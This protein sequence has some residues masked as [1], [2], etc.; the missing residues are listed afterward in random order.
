MIK[1][2]QDIDIA[3]LA[4]GDV[5]LWRT[6]VRRISPVV[7]SVIRGTLISAGRD[8]GEAHDL[9]Q[10]LFLRLCKDN[11]RLLKQYNPERARLSTWLAVIA[12]NMTIDYL[13]RRRPPTISL[14]EIPEQGSEETGI[15][16]EMDGIVISFQVL[17][18]R[19]MMVMKLMYEK[20]MDVKEVADFMG[21]T[22]Q[23]VRSMHHKA[24]KKLRSIV[25]DG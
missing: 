24:V 7:F 11:F 3:L 6:F 20:D 2:E 12:R 13:R 25:A 19:Q 17:P 16:H 22:E 5:G 1:Q 4:K 9:L 18:P 23:S 10:E 15:G 8:G 21:I 14:E